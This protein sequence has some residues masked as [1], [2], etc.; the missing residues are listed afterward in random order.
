MRRI[1]S[2]YTSLIN[3]ENPLINVN[4]SE[5]TPN[6][7]GM[8]GRFVG[9]EIRNPQANNDKRAYFV[10]VRSFGSRPVQEPLL[11][12]G[13]MIESTNQPRYWRYRTVGSIGHGEG[14]VFLDIP[15]TAKE[16]DL[17]VDFMT[18][19]E[20]NPGILEAMRYH[21]GRLPK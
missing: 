11:V 21:M 2:A 1:L 3:V 12:V 6:G 9:Y 16:S 13:E 14:N 18:Q 8:S 20:M 7:K 10:A 4:F 15:E 19:L 5:V 17:V